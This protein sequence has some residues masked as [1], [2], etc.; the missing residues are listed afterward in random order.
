MKKIIIISLIL[1][2]LSGCNFGNKRIIVHE[3]KSKKIFIPETLTEKENK[4]LVPEVSN[5]LTKD[6][7]DRIKDY[8]LELYFKNKTYESRLVIIRD[9]IGNFNSKVT[10]DNEE[11]KDE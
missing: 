10:L 7:K 9:L 2:F 4:I 1:L 8:I 6:D 5:E 11:G 3:Y